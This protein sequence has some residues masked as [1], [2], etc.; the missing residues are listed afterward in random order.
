MQQAPRRRAPRNRGRVLFVTDEPVTPYEDALLKNDIDVVGV[1]SGAAALVALQRDRPHLVIASTSVKG[2]SPRELA[3]ALSRTHDGVPLI[4]IGTEPST[5]ARRRDALAVRAFDYFEMPAELES[6][7]LRAK[8]LIAI[9]QTIDRLRTESGLDY[10][11]GLANRRRF[12][13]ALTR[14][15]ERWRRYSV[16]CA[17]I[18]LDIDHLKVINDK[19]G[20]P[21]GDQVI[22]QTA[23]ILIQCSRDNDT[24]ARMGGEE[25]ALL[26]AGVTEDKAIKAAERLRAIL[27]NQPV[28]GVGGFTVSIGVA[29]C[30]AHADS[31]RKLYA[32][33]DAA[34]YLAKN[35]GRNQVCVAPEIAERSDLP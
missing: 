18:L 23:D 4:L 8:Q 25:F 29:G 19:F 2:I 34:L 26:L 28:E 35:Q 5:S 27:A 32:A 6:L 33:S 31:E 7:L 10:L 30:P 14:E 15:V 1:S 11:T 12:R 20:H 13:S 21:V 22:R 9:R 16:P 3:R 17:L 24:A